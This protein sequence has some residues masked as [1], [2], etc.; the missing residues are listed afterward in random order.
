MEINYHGQGKYYPGHVVKASDEG[1]GLW[2]VLYDDGDTEM[3]VPEH[4]LRLLAQVFIVM[5]YD[6]HLLH[7]DYPHS[8]H[9][10]NKND[11]HMDF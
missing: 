1:E 11:N 9:I 3:G 2:D 7:I 4:H 10:K 6:Y 8:Q 5:I